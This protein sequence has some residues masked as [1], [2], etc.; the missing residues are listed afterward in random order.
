MKNIKL[1]AISALFMANV[2]QADNKTEQ[3]ENLIGDM[4]EREITL[5]DEVRKCHRSNEKE[6]CIK[7]LI[8]QLREDKAINELP[9]Q[10]VVKA[11]LNDM[12]YVL[13]TEALPNSDDLTLRGMDRARNINDN[14]RSPSKFIEDWEGYLKMLKFNLDKV[15]DNSDD[16]AIC[17]CIE[18]QLKKFETIAKHMRKLTK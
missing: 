17:A 1:M 14:F 9:Y 12:F 5:K 13:K 7:N 8:K 11:Y 4:R 2:I 18:S 15:H 10:D 3:L 6:Q 16:P